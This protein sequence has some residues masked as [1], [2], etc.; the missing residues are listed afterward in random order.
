MHHFD[1]IRAFWIHRAMAIPGGASN[2]TRKA[3]YW[4]CMAQNHTYSILSGGNRWNCW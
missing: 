1:H 3:A 4:A 2:E